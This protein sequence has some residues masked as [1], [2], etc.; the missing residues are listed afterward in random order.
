[1]TDCRPASANACCVSFKGWCISLSAASHSNQRYAASASCRHLVL[2]LQALLHEHRMLCT[3]AWSTYSFVHKA[4]S[5]VRFWWLRTMHVQLSHTCKGNMKIACATAPL[6][7]G[8]RG[9]GGRTSHV[10]LSQMCQPGC[11]PCGSCGCRVGQ[12]FVV[13]LC[14]LRSDTRKSMCAKPTLWST[15]LTVAVESILPRWCGP[16]CCFQCHQA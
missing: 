11:A 13:V 9:G 15:G 10:Q 14:A 2:L 1:M 6:M 7:F 8:A 12:T 3:T 4:T 5:V 16:V